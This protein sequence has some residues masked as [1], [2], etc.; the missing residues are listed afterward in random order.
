MSIL[1]NAYRRLQDLTAA[2]PLQ[3]G[4][5]TAASSGAATVG[6]PGG[7]TTTVR[8]TA[9]VGDWV[10]IRD[11]VIEGEAPALPVELIEI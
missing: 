1:R 5:V 8:G 3:V 7:G 4:V 6:L 10:F 11:G 2:P 9:L